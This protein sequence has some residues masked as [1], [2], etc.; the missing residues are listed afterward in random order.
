MQAGYAAERVDG[1]QR[2]TRCGASTQSVDACPISATTA[3]RPTRNRIPTS[4]NP[5]PLGSRASIVRDGSH[6]Q[7]NGPL[8]P[9]LAGRLANQDV[10]ID[11]SCITNQML[12]G[13]PCGDPHPTGQVRRGR[14]RYTL[15]THARREQNQQCCCK[16]DI[17]ASSGWN[18]W[19][20]GGRE[21]GC[22]NRGREY[23]DP[24]RRTPG[25][26]VL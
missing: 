17:R 16:H 20:Q 21:C 26:V 23:V 18:T 2:H 8:F 14:H 10:V 19:H 22:E 9:I 6:W 12:H 25:R 15:P 7:S 11:N 1:G 13:V 3:V 24:P 5:V 4:I